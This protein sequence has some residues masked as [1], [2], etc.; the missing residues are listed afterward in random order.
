MGIKSF[1]KIGLFTKIMLGF[2][3]GILAGVIMGEDASMFAFLGTILTKLLTMVVAPLVLC[4]I[5]VAVANMKD[6]KRIGR[7]GIKS[8]AIFLIS[9]LFAILVGLVFA[10]VMNIGS[11]VIIDTAIKASEGKNATVIDTILNIIPSNIFN[12]LATDSLLQIIFFAIIFGFALLKLG[13]KGE[14]L[15][16]LFKS[17][18]EVM[19]NVTSI[20][21]E[22]TPIGVFG[23][24]ANVIGNNGLDILIPYLK[25]I[26]ALYAASFFYL[27][28]VQSGIMVG[29]FGGMSP[30]R[31]LSVMKEPMAFVFASCSSVATMPLTL[32]STKKLGVDE[33]TANFVIPLGAVVNMNGTAIYQAIAVVFTAQV[34]GI[35]LSIADQIMVMLTATLAAIGTAGIPGSGLVMLTIVLGAA[36]L[37]MEGVALLAGIDRIL[38]M[39][40]VVPNIVGDA[41]TAVIVAKSEKTLTKNELINA[42][43]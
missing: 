10:N 20:I 9:T 1:K 21:L 13:Q 6:G 14:M 24:M 7:I 29:L 33:D 22:Y 23:L 12:S 16:N 40:R 26:I 43:D 36:N 31:F 32:N 18:Q 42:E 38:N 30:R 28:V 5:V 37:P 2:G 17:G 19:Q 35:Q 3:A 11:G 39:G 15:L 41:A 4:V 27:I 8:V 34:F 25:A